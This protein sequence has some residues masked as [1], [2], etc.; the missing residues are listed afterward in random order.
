MA[1]RGETP[2]L[3]IPL[4]S[5]AAEDLAEADLVEV[6]D[7]V[8]PVEEVGLPVRDPVLALQH[9]EAALARAD[10]K[11]PDVLTRTEFRRLRYLLSFARLTVFEPG[12]AGPGGN[13]GRG[14][15]SVRAELSDFRARVVDALYGPLREERRLE[16]RLVRA[17]E[18]L[19]QLSPD[20]EAERDA[21]LERHANDFSANE[22]DAEVGYKTLVCVLG[23]GG[24]A[25]YVYLGGMHRLIERGM[26][27][28]YMLTA[29]F[30]AVVGSVVAR[31]TPVPIDE[32]FDWAKTVTYR[33]ILGP[34]PFRRRHGLNGLFSLTFDT[35]ADAMFRNADG[36]PVRMKDLAI[37]YETVIAGVR[38]QSFDRLPSRFRRSELAAL[39]SRA[40]PHLKI[41]AAAAGA[42]RMW[43]V[44][45]FI[46]SRVVKPIVL[47]GDELTENLNVVDAVSFSSAIPGVLHHESKDPAMW[48]LLDELMRDKDVAAL[49]DGGA[50]SNVPAELAWKRIQDGRLGTRNAC[51]YAWDCFHP[52][53]NPRHLWLQPITQA[54]QLQMVRNAPYADYLV[55]FSPSLS[56]VTLAASPEA[57]DRAIEWGRDAVES[58][59]PMIEHLLEPVWW[60]GDGP[61][62]VG[63]KPLASR[64]VSQPMASIIEAARMAAN[65]LPA[66]KRMRDRAQAARAARARTKLDGS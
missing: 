7:L 35:F 64:I 61:P 26:T 4:T 41:G 22:L 43:Q 40:L 38:R 44:A 29:S 21:L 57:I 66:W 31:V 13:R 28:G 34:E 48:P 3:H 55:R 51:F 16:T 39:G 12:A 20:L 30:G 52:Q 54:V 33:G 10:L 2:E 25:G 23:G 24:G 65:P 1:T 18:A 56:P 63:E 45:A 32:Y 27:P 14:D 50:A 37:P 62:E 36:E 58:S 8:E 15:V 42:T 6:P 11:H 17:K 47:G 19:A 49:V 60:S 59:L 46:D 9:M 53:W 5:T